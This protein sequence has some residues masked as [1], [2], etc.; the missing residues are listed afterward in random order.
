MRHRLLGMAT[1][2]AGLWLLAVPAGGQTPAAPPATQAAGAAVTSVPARTPDGQPDIQGLW[3]GG[4]TF[5]EKEFDRPAV[6]PG[7]SADTNPDCIRGNGVNSECAAYVQLFTGY[8]DGK[9]N[10][11]RGATDT[12]PRRPSGLIDLPD[13]KLPWTPAG[14]EK[15][16]ELVKNLFD[17]PTLEHVDPVA[18][19]IPGA[20]RGGNPNPTQILQIPGHV[21][22]AGEFN[23][24]T[25]IIPVD[26]RP[27]L[28]PAIRLHQGDSVGRWEGTTL[29]LDT[30]NFVGGGMV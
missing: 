3:E 16:A 1:V 17:P 2:I 9:P 12:A 13:G 11:G 15:R 8:V 23:H 27:H 18:R 21:V 22:I 4:A 7:P 20:P 29:V 10:F 14:A 24:I 28:G 26:G 25:R 5:E 30:T 6:R 19:C